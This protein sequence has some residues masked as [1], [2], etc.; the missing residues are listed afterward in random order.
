MITV[1]APHPD[2]AEI[3]ASTFLRPGTRILG[4][5][6]SASRQAE[7]IEAA[8]RAGA[9]V[10]GLGWS[11]GA[12]RHDRALVEAIEPM[13]RESSVVLSPP[14]SD[15]HQD[16]RAVAL[17]VRS[18]LRRSP[19]TVLEYETPS[20]TSSWEPNI[21]VP[22][23]AEDLDLQERMLAAFRSQSDR[24]YFNPHVIEAR[25]LVHG[26]RVGTEYAQAFRIVTGVVTGVATAPLSAGKE[27]GDA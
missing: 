19:V 5:T 1:I 18:A 23:T 20:T 11:E 17:A 12:L 10:V 22:M 9:V 16:H 21:F 26:M 7:Q 3:G 24:P 8:E 6:G 25:A 4:I 2:D 27:G 15:T 13:A 14:L